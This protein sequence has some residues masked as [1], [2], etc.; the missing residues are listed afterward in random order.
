MTLEI[1]KFF[2]S[3]EKVIPVAPARQVM[4]K[5]LH[6][7]L[8]AVLGTLGGSLAARFALGLGWQIILPAA[9]LALTAGVLF[10]AVNMAIDLAR[11]LLTWT[12]PVRA[13]KQNL[14]V[15]LAMALDAGIVFAF[16]YLAQF[17]RQAGLGG[18]MLITALFV[19][20][21]VF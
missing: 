10:T 16:Y 17:L 9:L 12:N 14:N 11:P 8:V 15:V 7:Y 6:S 18:S 20:L 13:I 21:I 1:Q 4:G 5:F 3:R 19:A 2:P